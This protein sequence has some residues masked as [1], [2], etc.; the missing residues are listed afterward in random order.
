M[1]QSDPPQGPKGSEVSHNAS[2]DVA[3]REKGMGE[4]LTTALG[5]EV[6]IFTQTDR[7]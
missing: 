4:M 6:K 5:Q 1:V 3:S 7:N 2:R